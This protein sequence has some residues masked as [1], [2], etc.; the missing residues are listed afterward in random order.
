MTTV[1]GSTELARYT[2]YKF[3]CQVQNLAGW[4]A[5]VVSAVIRML[6]DL[7]AAPSAPGI[8][9][10]LYNQFVVTWSAPLDSATAGG[11]PSSEYSYTLVVETPD[12]T[13]IL[14]QN[15]AASDL[16]AAPSY[17]VTGLSAVT[18]YNVKISATNGAGTGPF[19]AVS[20][21]T[22]PAAVPNQMAAPGIVSHASRTITCSF[23]APANNGASITAYSVRFNPI[24][25]GAIWVT[26]ST[27]IAAD[28]TSY[29]VTGLS[30]NTAYVLQVLAT[31]SVGNSAWSSS[32]TSHTTDAEVPQA[33]AQPSVTPSSHS[34]A[35]T[36]V[37]PFLG[38]LSSATGYTVTVKDPSIA[39]PTAQTVK[40]QN[41]AGDVL[42]YTV[43]GLTPMTT[44]TVEVLCTNTIG[45]GPYSAAN[46]IST[47]GA[48]PNVMAAPTI[49]AFASRTI[50]CSFVAPA[51]NGGAITSYAVQYKLKYPSDSTWTLSSNSIAAS[52]SSYQ[53][54]GLSPYQTYVLQVQAQNSFGTSAWSP[55]SSSQQTNAEAPEAPAQPSV[56]SAQASI[57]VTWNQPGM[58]GLS[59]LSGYTLQLDENNA[60]TYA[61]A[62]VTVNQ[63]I[64]SYTWSTSLSADSTFR[65][66]IA[67]TNAIG[68]GPYS[69]PSNEISFF[70]EKSIQFVTR[71]DLPF[72]Q[73]PSKEQAYKTEIASKLNVNT[74]KIT[75]TARAGS[76][77]VTNV[78]VVESS[79][80]AAAENAVQTMQTQSS[81]N[82]LTLGGVSALSMSSPTSL[83]SNGPGI[84]TNKGLVPNIGSSSGS[85]VVT[86]TGSG[87]DSFSSST[88]VSCNGVDIT[89]SSFSRRSTYQTLVVT[90]PP[91]T[92]L[93]QFLVGIKGGSN[94]V[95]FYQ[96]T[97]SALTVQSISP[98]SGNIVGGAAGGGIVTV[99]V[100]GITGILQLPGFDRTGVK[101]RFGT[102]VHNL[103]VTAE[104][105]P[106]SAGLVQCLPPASSKAGT[107]K[108]DISLNH[109]QH[110]LTSVATYT[111]T[112]DSNEYTNIDGGC[113]ACPKG[114]LCDGTICFY[115]IKGYWRRNGNSC[116]S[117]VYECK[118]TGSCNP[119]KAVTAASPLSACGAGYKDTLCAVCADDYYLAP[120][121]CLSCTGVS[122]ALIF[123]IVA[124]S[125]VL[126]A[127]LV[128]WIVNK[129]TGDDELDGTDVAMS[130][131]DTLQSC[132]AESRRIEELLVTSTG[133]E[134]V[135]LQAQLDASRQDEAAAQEQV[136]A[137]QE[138]REQDEQNEDS[139]PPV[140]LESHEA[141]ALSESN[142]GLPDDTMSEQKIEELKETTG[143]KLDELT[144]GNNSFV[145]DT[146][147]V[148]KDQLDNATQKAVDA[149]SSGMDQASSLFKAAAENI[150]IAASA[151]H[152]LK[153]AEQCKT[154]V[155]ESFGQF[156]IV[157]STL[158]V[159]HTY[160]IHHLCCLQIVSTFLENFQV[161][162]P[163]MFTSWIESIQI[164]NL[165]VFDVVSVQ[166]MR[167]S[168]DFYSKLQA[169][170]LF[171][172]VLSIIIFGI[173]KCRVGTCR[174]SSIEQHHSESR[175][176]EVMKIQ[177]QHMF[178]FLLL[179]FVCY[180]GVSSVV[181]RHFKYVSITPDQ[182]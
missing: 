123:V 156:K 62:T 39:D 11:N 53:V 150:N 60:G 75:L 126:I 139:E 102:G 89:P 81:S 86:I 28:Q 34:L 163:S 99:T 43:T 47:I 18:A 17:T 178:A 40:T 73:W 58:G 93:P 101:C 109:E 97:H 69:T 182:S 108:L 117:E 51:N 79:N 136:D 71:L 175:H 59:A 104:E 87:A 153:F 5:L 107:F 45:A 68:T 91:Q 141:S 44:Y 152:V 112:C 180:A 165:A 27:S 49:T 54:T 172:I 29:Q 160:H 166:C 42:S 129:C 19:S 103:I 85:T 124:L 65:V 143:Q 131:Q 132:Q 170:I 13:G 133:A 110:W 41:L 162:W 98:T 118:F 181:M 149:A 95:T 36:W 72:S 115:P 179:L 52:A 111:Y 148:A 32:S 120:E 174:G 106:L 6:P 14:N 24:D 125:L 158:Q 114:A 15:F 50:T 16:P 169:S 1:D 105:V 61:A 77:V 154:W 31:N 134:A 122:Q 56:S 128:L 9:S 138:E 78:A 94:A 142:T 130:A 67:A 177:S 167:P 21:V 22:T 55:S 145:S 80:V 30:P 37:Q 171:P 70:V 173:A 74:G 127:I 2:Q 164:V 66:R 23:S 161:P 7:P 57:T 159:P 135:A 38:G 4:S 84:A 25:D 100:T 90:L 140:D 121:G 35:V 144:G 10:T 157:F 116:S 76:T 92:G 176:K 151:E 147:G 12:G 64:T 63:D 113:V 119:D 146:I 48:A 20:S 155:E 26:A 137:E 33:P 83:T 3:Y 88:I 46:S 168:T 82:A 8:S 96:Y